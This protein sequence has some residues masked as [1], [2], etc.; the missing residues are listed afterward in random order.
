MIPFSPYLQL[1]LLFIFLL[2]IYAFYSL[3]SPP[4]RVDPK[5]P[6]LSPLS[7]LSFHRSALTFFSKSIHLTS[8]PIFSY[9]LPGRLLVH[10]TG[11]KGRKI[12]YEKK[13]LG[14]EEGYSALLFG[15]SAVGLQSLEGERKKKEQ[16]RAFLRLLRPERIES[17]LPSLLGDVEGLVSSLHGGILDPF[18]ALYPLVFALTSRLIGCVE[19][20]RDNSLL[21]DLAQQFQTFE[22]ATGAFGTLI[23]PSFPSWSKLKRNW[24][25]LRCFLLLQKVIKSRRASGKEEDDGLQTIL[26]LEN[27]DTQAMIFIIGNLMAGQTN[28]GYLIPWSLYYI[29]L[30]PDIQRKIHEEVL[31]LLKSESDTK[32]E[33]V[34]LEQW[35]AGLDTLDRCLRETIRLH[36]TGLHARATMEEDMEVDGFHVPKGTLFSY[37]PTDCHHDPS[38][39]P[40]PLDFDIGRPEVAFL[41]WGAGRHPCLGARFAKLEHKL[42]L[43]SLIRKFEFSVASPS[44]SGSVARVK[45]DGRG[46]TTVPPGKEE[47]ERCFLR[48]R[49]RMTN[50]S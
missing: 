49:R 35:E 29:S 20:A 14:F 48:V 15:G 45:P 26:E 4:Q 47:M 43:A 50:A 13:G 21:K 41:G 46:F 27:D 34:T 25:G 31:L 22:D 7:P 9:R 32:W 16:Q 38:I 37:A 33:E 24:A 42:I 12:F 2:C 17:L 3:N 39:Y 23:L 5:L 18:E 30:Y 10:L 8:S 44:T 19:V 40:D 36:L 1:L 28:A 6:P 11:E